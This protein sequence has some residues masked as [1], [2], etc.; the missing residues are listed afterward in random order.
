MLELATP[1]HLHYQVNE[2]GGVAMLNRRTG[3][4]YAL[5][6]TAGVLWRNWSAGYGFEESVTLIAAHYPDMA[7][8]RLRADAARLLEELVGRGLVRARPRTH[9]AAAEMAVDDVTASSA[10]RPGQVALLG[11]FV[12]LLFSVVIVRFPFRAACAAVRAT[13]R[14]SKT[15]VSVSQAHTRVAAV[16]RVARW[17]PVRVACLEKSLAAVFLTALSGHRLAWCLGSMPDP[18]RFHAWVEAEGDIIP[19]AGEPLGHHRYQRIM[20][21]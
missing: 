9:P 15:T 11:A 8:D 20:S 16:D 3:Q 2:H 1:D 10:P 5:N 7:P 12:C 18:Y 4:W 14:W 13:R 6:H 19:A 21:L 17:F